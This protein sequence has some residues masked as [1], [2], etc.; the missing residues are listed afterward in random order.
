MHHL[1]TIN[2]LEIDTKRVIGIVI[3]YLGI[4]SRMAQNRVILV[5]MTGVVTPSPASAVDWAGVAN[6]LVRSALCVA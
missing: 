1:Q 3:G 2:I 5:E 6:S 4:V